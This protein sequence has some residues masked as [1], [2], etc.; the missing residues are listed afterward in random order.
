MLIL[1]V[2]PDLTKIDGP[3]ST[4]IVELIDIQCSFDV[5]G[6]QFSDQ[7]AKGHWDGR[8]HLFS[9]ATHAFASG[10]LTR[11]KGVLDLN[12]VEYVVNDMRKCPIGLPPITLTD[13]VPYEWQSTVLETVE[14]EKRG[15]IKIATGGGKSFMQT[16][17]VGK[18]HLKTIILVN[19][20]DILLQFKEWM[21]TGLHI[22]PGQIGGGIVKPAHITLMMV[23][24]AANALKIKTE[25]NNEKDVTPLTIANSIIIMKTLNECEC[26]IVDEVHGIISNTWYSMHR[27]FKHAYYKL[28][29]SATPG[30][31]ESKNL[32]LEAAFGPRLVDITCSDLIKAG[33][34][35]Q[36]YFYFVNLK[37]ERQPKEDTYPTVYKNEIT[38]NQHRNLLITS[39]A[40]SYWKNG[41]RVLIGVQHLKHGLILEDML[42]KVLGKDHVIFVRGETDSEIRRTVLKEL[43]A[44]NSRMVIATKVFSEGIDLPNLNVLINAKA[45]ISYI[46]YLQM[47]GRVLRKVEGKDKAFI[48]DFYDYGCKYLTSHSKERLQLAT[49]EPEFKIHKIESGKILPA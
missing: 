33:Y 42:K 36:P 46:D 49:N 4:D 23:Q 28:G 16:V 21:E 15:I 20:L 9:K 11:V 35:T 44:G 27:Y 41:N 34:L 30:Y 18:L 13:K 5:E 43:N 2:H 37:H 32:L 39:I 24:T 47:I 29:W 1:T 38:E 45:Q 17:L 40:T 48:I 8:R 19:K 31:L 26:L 7:V 25:G 14:R 22:T 6:A 3:I 12:N 10:L